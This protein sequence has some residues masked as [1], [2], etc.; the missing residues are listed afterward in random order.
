[1]RVFVPI[2]DEMMRSKQAIQG[3]LVPFRPDF[4]KQE[5]SSAV[6]GNKPAN[7]ISNDD[8]ATACKRLRECRA[9]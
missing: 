6:R 3:A 2:T 8:Y 4:L 9:G 1:M 7:W 5:S